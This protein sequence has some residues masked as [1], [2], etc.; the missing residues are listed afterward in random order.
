L[1]TDVLGLEA[2]LMLFRHMCTKVIATTQGNCMPIEELFPYYRK[3]R[4][5]ERMA[6]SDVWL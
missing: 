2:E 5:P 3:S 4:S 1:A 6:G